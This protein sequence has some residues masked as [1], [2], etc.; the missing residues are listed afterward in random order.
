MHKEL[1][2]SSV[3]L[4]LLGPPK[5]V[6][7]VLK[8]AINTTISE[9]PNDAELDRLLQELL[10]EHAKNEMKEIVVPLLNGNER[11]ESDDKSQ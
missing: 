4:V 7:T 2:A 3:S 6:T 11:P 8:G 10:S 1:A 9:A 5:E